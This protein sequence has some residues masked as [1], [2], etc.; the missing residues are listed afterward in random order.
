MVWTAEEG[1]FVLSEEGVDF[2]YSDGVS[3]ICTFVDVTYKTENSMEQERFIILNSH[4]IY[5]FEFYKY[6]YPHFIAH[7]TFYLKEK[8][9]YPKSIRR[10]LAN[11]YTNTK[12][13]EVTKKD[14]MKRLRSCIYDKYFLVTQYKNDVQSLEGKIIFVM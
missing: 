6:G 3:G 11:W 1:S 14:C 10:E 4:G 2:F 5:N 13:D 7:I 8:F 12:G 9:E